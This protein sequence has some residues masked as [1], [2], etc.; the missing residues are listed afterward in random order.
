MVRLRVNRNLTGVQVRASQMVERG[1]YAL[2]NQVYA[3]SNMYAP[4]LSSD[5]R[6]QSQVA[7]DG[8]SITW[9]APYARRQYYNV[10]ANFTAP[11]TGPKWDQKAKAIHGDSWKRVTERAMR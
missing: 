6:N 5:L 4:V 11:G 3:D 1:Q 8:K 10:G 2:V 7:N 9:N